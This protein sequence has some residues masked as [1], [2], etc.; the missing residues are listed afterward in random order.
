MRKNEIYNRENLI[1]SFL[2]HT[3]L[4]PRPSPPPSTPSSYFPGDGQ[5]ILRVDGGALA[6][7]R[8]LD[9]VVGRCGPHFLQNNLQELWSLLHFLLPGVF[10][11]GADFATWFN[12]TLQTSG[13]RS[14]LEEEERILVVHRLH[15]VLR[16]RGR[17]RELVARSLDRVPCPQ[18]VGVG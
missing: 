11:D 5:G 6:G 7:L 1:A 17:G 12:S 18:G 15:Q 16:W 10:D 2:V 4:G 9:C 14:G 8:L 13:E 3:L